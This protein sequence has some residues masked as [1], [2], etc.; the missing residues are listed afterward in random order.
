MIAET[1]LRLGNTEGW[2]YNR[3]IMIQARAI[4]VDKARNVDWLKAAAYVK[5]VY[6]RFMC[7]YLWN[8]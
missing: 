7:R 1:S 3:Q 8:I 5:K 4:L 2:N 6:N